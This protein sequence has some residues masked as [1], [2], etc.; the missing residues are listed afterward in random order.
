MPLMSQF[1]SGNILVITWL[2][3]NTGQQGVEKQ[4][5]GL[6]GPVV[7]GGDMSFTVGKVDI[8]SHQT[9]GQRPPDHIRHPKLSKTNLG[10]MTS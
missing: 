8:V 6:S 1:P 7:I 10:S 3:Q 5:V 4:T 2:K 9:E